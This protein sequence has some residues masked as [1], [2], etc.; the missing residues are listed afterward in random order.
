MSE[1]VL[2]ICFLRFRAF[3]LNFS[4]KVQKNN[5][6]LGNIIPKKKKRIFCDNYFPLVFRTNFLLVFSYFLEENF[7]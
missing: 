1:I 2:K 3:V 4:K 5:L 7:L 6:H